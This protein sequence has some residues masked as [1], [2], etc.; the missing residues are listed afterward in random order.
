MKKSANILAEPIIPA[1]SAH[2]VS[3]V[4]KLATSGTNVV[5]DAKI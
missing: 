1:L 4:A 5:H 3:N 2:Q